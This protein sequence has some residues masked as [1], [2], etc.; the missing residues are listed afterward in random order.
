[1]DPIRSPEPRRF[2][3]DRYEGDETSLYESARGDPLKRDNFNF[4][5]GRRM[6]QGVHIAERS[7]FLGMS[8]ILW[9]FDLQSPLDSAG[10]RIIP[11]T[12][13]L[14]G[15]ITV[16]PAPYEVDFVPRSAER[17]AIVRQAVT[18]CEK[19]LSPETKQWKKAPEGMAFGTAKAEA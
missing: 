10:N 12:E 6:C 15:G 4:G 2:N 5:A 16:T 9:L 17:T 7:L 11:D 8:R 1:M 14:I 19:L 18:D 3:P 13:N